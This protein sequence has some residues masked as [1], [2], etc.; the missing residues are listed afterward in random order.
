MNINCIITELFCTGPFNIWSLVL[1]K[2]NVWFFPEPVPTLLLTLCVFTWQEQGDAP[3]ADPLVLGAVGEGAQ[4]EHH[5]G[6][7]A[8]HRQQH[9]GPGGVPEGCVGGATTTF[10]RAHVVLGTSS[11]PLARVCLACEFCP[12]DCFLFVFC[13]C[14]FLLHPLRSE[15]QPSLGLP[16][17]P[18]PSTPA[19]HQQSASPGVHRLVRTSSLIVCVCVPVFWK[20]SPFLF[21]FWFGLMFLPVSLSRESTLAPWTSVCQAVVHSYFI[22]IWLTPSKSLQS[23]LW[24]PPPKLSRYQYHPTF[25]F[26]THLSVLALRLSLKTMWKNSHIGWMHTWVGGWLDWHAP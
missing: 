6:E 8:Q 11:L 21:F 9:E 2:Q 14:F 22:L 16:P 23:A 13:F 19:L 3:R 5:T 7:A 18:S 20:N 10:S 24:V 12:P 1:Q 26:L 25:S 17:P 15:C 4:A